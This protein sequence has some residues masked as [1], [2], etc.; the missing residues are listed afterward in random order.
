MVKTCEHCSML[1]GLKYEIKS[2]K[3]Y[4]YFNSVIYFQVNHQ[5]LF[6]I[7]GSCNAEIK[8]KYIK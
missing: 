1:T 8:R 2:V 3:Q 5:M 7:F 4:T 6:W